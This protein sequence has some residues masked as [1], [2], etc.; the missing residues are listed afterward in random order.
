MM[1]VAQPIRTAWQIT[2]R[3]ARF[4]L[5]SMIFLL[6]RFQAPVSTSSVERSN[7]GPD[8]LTQGLLKMGVVGVA[9]SPKGPNYPQVT[10]FTE[11]FP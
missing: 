4:V 11:E 3:Q 2:K 7:V 9:G 1:F 5:Q 6:H 8:S 10:H